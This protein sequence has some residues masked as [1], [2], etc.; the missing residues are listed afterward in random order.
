MAEKKESS[1][2]SLQGEGARDA[3]GTFGDARL[4]IPDVAL[5]DYLALKRVNLSGGFYAPKGGELGYGVGLSGRLQGD[6]PLGKNA[7]VRPYIGGVIQKSSGSKPHARATDA[8]VEFE[9]KF[10]KGGTVRGAGC[11][12]KGVKKCK[13]R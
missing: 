12:T 13:I 10:A 9:Y 1:Q 11:A 4:N 6:V 8:G 2:T 3:S 5:N 7:S